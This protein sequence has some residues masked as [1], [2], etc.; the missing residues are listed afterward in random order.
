MAMYV[1]LF[2]MVAVAM[3]KA[4]RKPVAHERRAK[5]RPQPKPGTRGIVDILSTSCCYA[6]IVINNERSIAMHI[7]RNPG[8]R[9]P[10]SVAFLLALVLGS[11]MSVPAANAGDNTDILIDY[12][13]TNPSATWF[14]Q[15]NASYG[16][17]GFDYN[18]GTYLSPYNNAWLAATN[19]WSAI[20]RT[21]ILPTPEPTLPDRCISSMSI[22]KVSGQSATINLEVIDPTTWTYIA[23]RQVTVML[24]GY[25]RFYLDF[26]PTRKDVIAR[27]ALIGTDYY[28]KV[29]LDSYNMVCEY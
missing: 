4:A 25:T 15:H 12:L 24:N 13:D 22:R 6:L 23:F 19:G 5:E 29:R 16:A 26:V 17:G 1:Q 9:T 18:Q 10:F 8:L 2:V 20:G 14:F 11:G 28:K 3:K 27:F 7:W 21:V